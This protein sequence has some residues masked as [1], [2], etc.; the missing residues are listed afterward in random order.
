VASVSYLPTGCRRGCTRGCRFCSPGMLTRP[1]R[2]DLPHSPKKDICCLGFEPCSLCLMG[3]W[4][5]HKQTSKSAMACLSLYTLCCPVSICVFV[6]RCFHACCVSVHGF[7]GVLK[8][9]C[10]CGS[11]SAAHRV[12]RFVHLAYAA[13]APETAGGHSQ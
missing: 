2:S 10:V 7:A 9:A 4:G 11:A 1:A 13:L 5:L 12:M 8:V 3:R 6:R